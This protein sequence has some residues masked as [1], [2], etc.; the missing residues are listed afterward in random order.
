MGEESG[1][2]GGGGGG[3]VLVFPYPIQGHINPMIQLSKR[4]SA[5]GLAVTLVVASNE[6]SD[7]YVAEYSISLRTI[8]NGFDQHDHPLVMLRRTHRFN[9]CTS[10]SLSQ[11]IQSEM[12]SERPPKAVIYDPFMPWAL[13]VAKDLGLRAVAYFTQPWSVNLIYHHINEGTYH[14]PTSRHDHPTLS[15]F[16]A[17]PLLSQKDLPSFACESGSYPHLFDLVVS[18]FSNFRRADC[19]LCNTFDQ[20]E[21]KVMKW[22]GKEWPVKNIGPVVPSKFLDNRLPED[23][24]YGLGH[25]RPKPGGDAIKWLQTKPSKSVVYVSYGTLAALDEKQMKEIAFGMR[26]SGFSFLWSLR[27]S[28]RNKLPHGFLEEVSKNDLGLVVNW[29]SQLEVLAQ[30]SVGCF[31][32][33]CGWNSTL[34]ALCMGIP[35]VGMPQWTDQPTNAK[36]IEDVWKVGVRV[37]AE[38]D[39][40]VKKEEISRC[41]REVMEGETGK[42]MRKNA[43]KWKVL[44]CEAVSEGGSSDR[45]L[46]E[47][48][49]MFG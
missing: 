23:K 16:P 22:M 21:D 12:L 29:T 10:R 28:E 11:F 6:Q 3:H 46:D 32:T 4:L 13:D 49:A 24:D 7:P 45:N 8:F 38:K 25:F 1:N 31:V 48:V 27:D 26:E 47:F 2:G 18:Q 19:I 9:D 36:F 30:G 39:G 33:H 17:L 42:E 34:E 40:L 44:A 35:L 15:S 14:V 37:K 43:E 41:V 5:K 20:L